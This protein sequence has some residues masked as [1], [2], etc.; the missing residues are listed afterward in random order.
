MRLDERRKRAQFKREIIGSAPLRAVIRAW[1][2]FVS[3]PLTVSV[4]GSCSARQIAPADAYVECFRVLFVVADALTHG[5][6]GVGLGSAVAFFVA[7]DDVDRRAESR[8]C[9]HHAM[10]RIAPVATGAP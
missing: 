4:V 2:R 7:I 5:F 9:D 1:S 8:A 10:R 3:D 6:L